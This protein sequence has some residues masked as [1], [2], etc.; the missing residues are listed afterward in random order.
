MNFLLSVLVTLPLAL[1][2]A[3][4]FAQ[5]PDTIL[6]NGK[7]VTADEGNTVHQALAVREGR[8]VA[9]G[10]SAAI[11]RLAGKQT[12]VVDLGGRTV[13]P[14]LIDSHMHAIRAALSYGTEV[15]WFG[16]K[17]IEEAL[18]RLRDA[19][20]A[21]KPGAWLIVAGGWTEEQFQE[22][23]R[24]TQA[25]LVAAAPDNPVY[26]QWMYGWAMLTPLAYTAL[27][28]NAEADLPAGAK[29]VRDASGNPTGAVAGGIV[30]LFDKLPTPGFEQKVEGTR[31]FF[32]EL[33]RVGLTGVVDPGGFNMSP[34]QYAP[35]FQV[36]RDKALSVRVSY[37][38]FSQQRGKELDEFKELTQLLPMGFGDDMLRFNGIGE[39]VTF[40]MYN[41]D[42][43]TEGQKE[44]FYQAARWAAGRGMTLTQ[45]WHSDASVGH[46]LEVFERVDREVPIG[47]LRWSIAHL[48]DGSEAT[49]ARM[50]ALGVGWAMQDAMYY[51]GERALK[52]KGAAALKRMPPL[53]TAQ[54][55]GVVIGAG[56]D[57]HRVANYNPFV[58]LRWMLDG[59]SAGGVALRGAEETPS[60]IAALR[61]YTSGS[62]WFAHDDAR[63]GTLG[64]GKLADLAVL[65]KDYLSVPVDEIGGIQSL[66]T[67]VGGRVVYADG[68][69]TQSEERR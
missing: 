11:K 15:H 40:G 17:S 39:R 1:T 35:L 51:Q 26:V 12:R 20:R 44:E 66:L 59:K 31:K 61:M 19:A 28:I 8:I 34:Q 25:E 23:R 43:P 49:F 29:F 16:T 36:W 37:S 62:A 45:H 38:Y 64:V 50:K 68:P 13:I 30:G 46:L 21:A 33:N 54:K 7:I 3:A 67:M 22:R 14:G 2:T 48:N 24:P 63:R 9:L 10:K 18:G 53:R 60:R 32:R 6:L 41:N 57:A 4:V 69:F 47:K 52:E 27:N 65:S 58:A 55:A 56:T 42:Q 5:A